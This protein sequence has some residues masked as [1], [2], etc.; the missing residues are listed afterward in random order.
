[1]RWVSVAAHYVSRYLEF[2]G[3]VYVCRDWLVY[4]GCLFRQVVLFAIIVIIYRFDFCVLLL[5]FDQRMP[6]LLLSMSHLSF[7]FRQDLFI[8][9]LDQ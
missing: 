7:S 1:M 6:D 9:L 3:T 5:L 4:Q 8:R 2:V